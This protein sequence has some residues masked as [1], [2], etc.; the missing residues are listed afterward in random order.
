MEQPVS[1]ILLLTYGLHFSPTLSNEPAYLSTVE[2]LYPAYLYLFNRRLIT[3]LL[4]E[5]SYLIPT[6]S[7]NYAR[8]V[9]N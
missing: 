4:V 8:Y 3:M 9:F 6:S 5:L 1:Y 7:F 2:A